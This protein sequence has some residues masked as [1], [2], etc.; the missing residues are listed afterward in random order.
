M[1]RAKR[2]LNWVGLGG[3]LLSCGMS[4]LERNWWLAFWQG[5]AASWALNICLL[6]RE[7]EHFDR[8]ADCGHSTRKLCDGPGFRAGETC[9]RPLCTN[10]AVPGGP[11]VHYCR[12]HASPVDRARRPS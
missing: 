6:E 9:G 10:C 4:L 1:I 11:N 8:C 3:A 5:I 12:R 2:V 7:L